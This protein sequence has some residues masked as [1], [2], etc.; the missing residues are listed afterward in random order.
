MLSDEGKFSDVVEIIGLRC[1]CLILD[2][3]SF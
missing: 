1:H 3:L 2:L